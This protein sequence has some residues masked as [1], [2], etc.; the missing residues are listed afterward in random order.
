MGSELTSEDGPEL[1]IRVDGTA[2]LERITVIRNEDDWRIF[3]DLDSNA[4]E[5]TF[6]DPEPN[7]GMNRYYVR[8]E[9]VD[10][11][12]AW[13]SPVWVTVGSSDD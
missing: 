8:V 6:T 5:K 1:R 3:E 2:P 10:G 12:M 13:S 11:N 4:F 7:D 9:Q